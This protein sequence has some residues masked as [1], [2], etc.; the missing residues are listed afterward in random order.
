MPGRIRDDDVVVVKERTNIAE[1]IGERVTL[2]SAGPGTLKGLCPFHDEKTPSMS[3]R[4]S[5]GSFHCFGCGEG[6]DV[7]SFLMKLDH[8]SFTEAVERLA[9]KAGVSLR[10]T[11]GGPAERGDPGQRARLLAA[12]RAAAAFY[13]EQL[14]G[15][16][17]DVARA[18]LSERGFDQT[19]A[20]RFGV[21]FAPR[22]WDGLSRHLMGRG[23]TA[24]ELVTG[25]LARPGQRGPM[26]AF[27]GRLVWPIRDIGGEVVGFGARRLFEDD[28]IAAKYVNTTETPI[29]K[30]SQVLYGLDLA[31]RD[32]AARRQAVVVEGYTDVMACHL[33]GVGTAVA[34]CGTAFGS[35][36]IKVLRRLLADTSGA[37]QF[38]GE[39]VFTFDGDEAGQKAALRA[40]G[41]DQ[42]FVAQTFVAVERGGLDP[43]ELRQRRGDAAVRE[44][45]AS[46]TPLFEF[47]IRS[48]LARHNLGTAEGRVAALRAA[49]PLVAGIRD[50][51]LRPEYAR[52]LAGWLGMDVDGVL[53]E[54]ARATRGATAGP[55]GLAG[56]SRAAPG[57]R[58]GT[59]VADAGEGYDPRDSRTAVE[60]EVLK[61]VLQAPALMGGFDDL[62]PDAL[63][64]QAHR[65]VR[66]GV[67]AAGGV[68]AVLDGTRQPGP[69][70]VDAVR[71]ACP[72]E[73]VR[74]LVTA[75]AVEPVQA[76]GELDARYAEAVLARVRELELSRR[77][78]ELHSRLQ[79][80]D[81]SDQA[82]TLDLLRQL[83][84]LEAARQQFRG[85]A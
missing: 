56:S 27:R 51:S 70:W 6:G 8:L 34:T 15:P 31:R 42:R 29:Y 66:L 18:F 4:P 46:R 52:Q 57:Q 79:R 50:L 10:Y 26:D 84:L 80:T 62:A 72:D 74:A 49:A 54:V 76:E 16:D 38:V 60:R 28:R 78:A 58:S 7:I 22:G 11:D 45:V 19:A 83:S 64:A 65:A 25:G 33:A 73:R 14:S 59:Q 24:E 17:A 20:E 21:G 23:Y 12:H 30:K 35:E 2:R 13:A 3:V 55:T 85:Q 1:V 40:F 68:A 36:H 75:L 9:A 5:V 69:G 41:D 61:V 32:I 39:V 43:C 67:L 77:A 53:A 44:L 81:P 82:A 63:G 47:A 71:E 48:T 37:D